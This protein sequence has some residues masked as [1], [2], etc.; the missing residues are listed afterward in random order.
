MQTLELATPHA[1]VALAP[2]TGGAIT[3]FTV[4]GMPVLRPTP[5]DALAASDVRRAS[6]YPLVP[7]SNRIR[8]AR[9]TFA[10]RDYPL[11]RNFGASPHAIHGVGW[12][13]PWRVV[14][15]ANDHARLDL[16][17]DA[18]GAHALAWPWPFDATLAFHLA[19]R[20]AFAVLR[21]TVAIR[22]TGDAPFPFGL[23]FHPFFPKRPSTRLGLHADAVW[24]ND[25]TQL[26]QERIAVPREW[27]F[28]PPRALDDLVV[29]NVFTGFAC[30]ATLDDD[31]VT[32]CIDADHALAFAVVYAPAGGDFVAVE[33]VSHETD[34]FNRAAAGA[35]GTGAR[36][37]RP[38]DAFSCTMRVAARAL[39]PLAR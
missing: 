21:A 17:H 24:L 2:A 9:L 1:R 19:E 38:G 13:R 37:L 25:A 20:G 16:V 34:A 35:T 22:N 26:P 28:D 36:I 3:G 32:R 7:Y 15:V 8:D 12:Q 5:G 4:R 6:C 10:G 39:D 18:R 23:G 11:A 31:R 29:D 14:E 27:R 30:R 33:P